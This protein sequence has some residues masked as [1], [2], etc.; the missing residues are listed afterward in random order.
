MVARSCA[1]FSERFFERY[2]ARMNARLDFIA[3]ALAGLLLGA[4][5]D[6]PSTTAPAGTTTAS[7]TPAAAPAHGQAEPPSLPPSHP[8]IGN[9]RTLTFTVPEGWVSETPSSAMR[10]AQFKLPRQGSDT[11]D[12]RLV[13]YFFGPDQGGSVE[14]NIQ[15]WAGE[16]QQPDGR[17]SIDVAQRSTRRVNGMDVTE[18]DVSG[19]LDAETMPG[20][21]Q[22]VRKENQRTLAAIVQS[23]HGSYF[24]KLTGPAATI[25]YWEPSFHKYV[26]SAT[27]PS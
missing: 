6:A 17:K 14:D 26:G 23:E 9:A 27:Q 11:E 12:A 19:T 4:C 18:V 25:A 1:G 10:K 13:V 20:S 8:P 15:R 22:R 5:T 16:Y 2:S 3:L 7:D 21:G 24:I